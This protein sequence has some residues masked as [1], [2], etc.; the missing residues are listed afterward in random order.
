M[1]IL[2]IDT[3]KT[4]E[5]VALQDGNR[6]VASIEWK[7]NRD[8]TVKLLPVISRILKKAKLNFHDLDSVTVNPGPGGFSALRIGVTVANILAFALGIPLYEITGKKWRKV[9]VAVPRYN[10]PPKITMPTK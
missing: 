8:E 7:G 10:I 3:T 5:T 6:N 9:K 4:E 2:F 1:K